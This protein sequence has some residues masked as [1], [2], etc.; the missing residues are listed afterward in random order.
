MIA[1]VLVSSFPPVVAYVG[2]AV[3]IAAAVLVA[4]W[5]AFRPQVKRMVAAS[6]LAFVCATVAVRAEEVV[7]PSIDWCWIYTLNPDDWYAYLRC[8]VQLP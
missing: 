2:L 7:I 5:G 8:V 4:H 3:T 6:L 1:I